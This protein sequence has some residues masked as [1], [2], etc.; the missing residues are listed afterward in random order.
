MSETFKLARKRPL[1]GYEIAYDGLTIRPVQDRGKIMLQRSNKVIDSEMEAL[2]LKF[3]QT[4]G[5]ALP[6]QVCRKSVSNDGAVSVLCINSNSWMILCDNDDDVRAI[7]D[8]VEK[9]AQGMTI[10]ATVMTDQNICLDIDGHRARML[11]AKGCA[12]D[13]L[14]ENFFEDH[15]AR[16]LLSQANIVIWR[17]NK[18]GFRILFDVCLSGYLWL[19][20]EGAAAEFAI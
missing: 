3:S 1:E 16:T 11:L 4:F 13:L 14:D 2:G 19:W 20:L 17:N 6:L 12:L 10:K 8:W 9:M 7:T 5:V 18:D 15:V